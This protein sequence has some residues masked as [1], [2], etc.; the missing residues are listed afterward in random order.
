MNGREAQASCPFMAMPQQ[1][2]HRVYVCMH[3]KLMVELAVHATRLYDAHTWY[4]CS[5][6]AGVRVIHIMWGKLEA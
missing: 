5:C 6:N 3:F 4:T 1:T 2:V